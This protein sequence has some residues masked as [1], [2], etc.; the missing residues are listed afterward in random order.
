MS[1][2]F[3]D[4][5]RYYVKLKMIDGLGRTATYTKEVKVA[6][7][8]TYEMPRITQ[9]LQSKKPI[10]THDPV[11]FS[12]VSQGIDYDFVYKYY[13]SNSTGNKWL[14]GYT[15]N[16]TIHFT[17]S[18]PDTYTLETILLDRFNRENI[19]IGELEV[20]PNPGAGV[21]TLFLSPS[22]QPCNLYWNGATSEREQM[23]I[24]AELVK[25][26]LED[27]KI[28]AIL[29]DY[30]LED[31]LGWREPGYKNEEAIKIT[32]R[33]TYASDLNADFYLA[34]HSNATHTAANCSG[35]LALYHP[36]STL[37]RQM[38]RALYDNMMAVTPYPDNHGGVKSGM[39]AFGGEGYGEVR[40][41][42]LL[43]IPSVLFEVNFHD[44]PTTGQWIL[45][46]RPTIANAIIKSI[47]ET[48]ELKLKSEEEI[49]EYLIT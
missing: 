4:P 23:E 34:I 49:E 35:P 24:V 9:V 15:T 8:P 43:G 38:A 16:P 7:D 18:H 36:N 21:K 17:F 39:D 22:N 25:E 37:S 42:F 20:L 13:L 32:G 10:F 46:N 3:N 2:K 31:R 19:Y 41:P 26:G 27:Y 11:R 40:S 12:A 48:L 44:N 1:Y 5:G 28:L 45:D 29:P 30:E 47:V 6:L 33:P 14:I